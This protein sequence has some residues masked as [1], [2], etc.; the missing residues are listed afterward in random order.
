MLIHCNGVMNDAGGFAGIIF[1]N[2]KALHVTVGQ[3]KVTSKLQMEIVAAIE[4]A[5]MGLMYLQKGDMIKLATDSQYV[6]DVCN[7]L[8]TFKR[9]GF[10]GL[11]NPMMWREMYEVLRIAGDRLYVELSEETSEYNQT[12][13]AAHLAS[14][15]S[16][17][18]YS[19]NPDTYSDIIRGVQL[20]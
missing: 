8:P 20:K 14:K 12:L 3:C 18:D 17:A 1:H 10:S 5:K 7:K 11:K 16:L 4:S 6:Y 9:Q 19:R 15:M 13:K 2:N